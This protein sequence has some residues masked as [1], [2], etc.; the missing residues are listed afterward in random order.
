MLDYYGFFHNLLMGG[1][2]ACRPIK[3]ALLDAGPFSAVNLAQPEDEKFYE[4]LP[5]VVGVLTK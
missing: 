1:C 2:K 3:Q 4:V 5:R